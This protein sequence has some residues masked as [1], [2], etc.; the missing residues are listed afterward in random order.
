MFRGETLPHAN[1]TAVLITVVTVILSHPDGHGRPAIF[2][3]P[4]WY[5]TEL[6]IPFHQASWKASAH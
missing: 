3:V 4:L 6:I 5:I 2:E 1:L